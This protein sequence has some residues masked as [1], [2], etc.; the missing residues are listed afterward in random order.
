MLAASQVINEFFTNNAVFTDY[1][2]DR[3]SPAFA[4]AKTAYP[5]A[6]YRLQETEGFTKDA[7]KELASVFIF[8]EPK[9]DSYLSL[10]TFAD[11]IKAQ[12]KASETLEWLGSELD[13]DSENVGAYVLTINLEII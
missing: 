10:V 8:M 12:I 5:F 4:P 13:Y 6:V 1:C 7:D 2:A 3:L 9:G 11:A